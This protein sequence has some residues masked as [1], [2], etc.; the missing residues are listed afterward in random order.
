MKYLL[1][2]GSGCIGMH[3]AKKLATDGATVYI[4]GRKRM[5]MEE[6]IDLARQ[7]II[8]TK[9]DVSKYQDVYKY[10][11]ETIGANLNGIAYLAVSCHEITNVKLNPSYGGIVRKLRNMV[12]SNIIG[13]ANVIDCSHPYMSFQASYVNVSSLGASDPFSGFVHYGATKAFVEAFT[14]GMNM[15]LQRKTDARNYMHLLR[16]GAVD[17]P[18]F[19]SL[20][21]QFDKT[22][23]LSIDKA[24]QA[25]CDL[26]LWKHT[27]PQTVELHCQNTT[28]QGV[29]PCTVITQN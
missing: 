9:L 10:M 22:K 23:V 27:C 24:S 7:K 6:R 29:E 20:F 11:K 5:Q 8:Y 26:L 3:V 17:T 14:R 13:L 19:W 4:C 28:Y 21:P 15:E 1:V 12:N 2:G 25:V 18:S 16:L